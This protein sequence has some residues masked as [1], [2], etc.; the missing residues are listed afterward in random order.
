MSLKVAT[1]SLM[2]HQAHNH[3]R[4]QRPL[5]RQTIQACS[6]VSETTL[7]LEDLDSPALASSNVGAL[8]SRHTDDGHAC[9]CLTAP[10]ADRLVR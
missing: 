4:L 6:C 7:P 1:A 10:D 3:R 2:R 8:R 5:Q 9:A